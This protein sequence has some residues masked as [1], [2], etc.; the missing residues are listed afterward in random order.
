MSR[1]GEQICLRVDAEL[2]QNLKLMFSGNNKRIRQ[3]RSFSSLGG[4]TVKLWG[5]TTG[6]IGIEGTEIIL[7][8]DLEEA[9][10]SGA[11]R[12]GDKL[13][14]TVLSVREIENHWTSVQFYAFEIEKP[15]FLLRFYNWLP[16]KVRISL[17]VLI[18]IVSGL[19]WVGNNSTELKNESRIKEIVKNNI[20]PQTTSLDCSATDGSIFD[21]VFQDPIHVY[22]DKLLFGNSPELNSFTYKNKVSQRTLRNYEVNSFSY[23]SLH[24]L[25][26]S[27]KKYLENGFQEWKEPVHSD[28][29][30][31]GWKA[32][33]GYYASI[34]KQAV[35]TPYPEYQS[36]S[37]RVY[38]KGTI[39]KD[40]HTNSRY[41]ILKESDSYLAFTE[42]DNRFNLTIKTAKYD[43]KKGVYQEITSKLPATMVFG[44]GESISVKC[45]Y[46]K[47]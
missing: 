28:K 46:L 10:D 6:M 14:L 45:D 33:E 36:D 3:L 42:N 9:I 7:P 2:I 13:F 4:S 8:V 27:E 20:Y 5:D 35:V 22:D 17:I 23:K 39:N 30:Y 43:K 18:V 34:S 1:S 21:V 29:E 47:E 19:A 44:N 37:A 41:M 38:I 15:F 24:R 31:Y 25:I 40:F 26:P 16:R 32:P 11:L 12:P